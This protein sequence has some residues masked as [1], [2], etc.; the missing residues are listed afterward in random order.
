MAKPSARKTARRKLPAP[1]Q[2]PTAAETGPAPAEASPASPTPPA[3]EADINWAAVKRLYQNKRRM[4][5]ADIALRYG[6]EENRLREIARE[7]R[8]LRPDS[9]PKRPKAPPTIRDRMLVLADGHLTQLEMQMETDAMPDLPESTRKL[10]DINQM[11]AGSIPKQP[12]P[13]EGAPQRASG[14]PT[15]GEIDAERWRLE[16]VERIRKLKQKLDAS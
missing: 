14:V 1:S 2:K 4:K 16:L 3:N 8:W 13:G 5:V 6:L 12:E 7:R 9:Q 11:V 10:R 15:S